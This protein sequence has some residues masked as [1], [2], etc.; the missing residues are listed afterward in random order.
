MAGG[1]VCPLFTDMS[2]FRLLSSGAAPGRMRPPILENLKPAVT[3]RR[4]DAISDEL[5]QR[6][7]V[8][9]NSFTK[10]YTILQT[11]KHQVDRD[12]FFL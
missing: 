5:F 6:K 3:N 10:P 11:L 1:M 8:S 12:R 9:K 7:C 4:R 2:F